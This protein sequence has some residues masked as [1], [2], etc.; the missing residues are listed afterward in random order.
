MKSFAE[1]VK[2]KPPKLLSCVHCGICLDVCPTYQISGD[3]NNSPRGRLAHWRAI[4][5]QRLQAGECTDF[6]L[7]ECLGCLACETA[8]PPKVLYGEL[9]NE[10][11]Q[12]RVAAGAPVDWRLRALALILPRTRL[13]QALYL[14][15]RL[16]RRSGLHFH[17]FFFPG[18]PAIFQSTAAYARRLMRRKKPDGPQVALFTGCL[19]E[20]AFRE[21]NF[22]TVRVLVANNLRVVVPPE[23]ACC[24]AVLEHTG[25]PGGARL[26]ERNRRAFDGLDEVAAVLT[27]A[28]GCGLTLGR[29]LRKP[30]RDVLVFL[31]QLDLRP[32]RPLATDHLYLDLPCHLVHGQKVSAPPEK[33]LAAIGNSWSLAPEAE[34]CCASGGTYNLTHPENARAILKEKSDFLNHTPHEHCTLVTTN[35]VCMMQWHSAVATGLVKKPVA[36]K[37]LVQVLDEAYVN[38][39]VYGDT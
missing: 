6:Y 17:R 24:G 29:A 8:C 2:E 16:L 12:V 33:V 23:Q 38:Q 36:V 21:I 11:R 7:S 28:A 5:E 9:L 30:T 39:G 31:N 32:G 26:A 27:N 34:R 20:A 3:E 19:M 37:H 10:A 1:L 35:H 18:R 13:F 15:L 22:A 25:L 4:S 14:P